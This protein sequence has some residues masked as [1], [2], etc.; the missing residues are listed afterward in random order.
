[1]KKINEV[2]NKEF[3]GV[4]EK[5]HKDF[6]TDLGVKAVGC[7]RSCQFC[8]RKCELPPHDDTIIHHNC[9]KRGH[10]MRAFGG[11]HYE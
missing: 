10:Q 9:S 4:I 5:R 2:K 7:E 8:N 6:I 1:M 3:S 11:G